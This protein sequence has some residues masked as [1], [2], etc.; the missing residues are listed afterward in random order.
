MI[1]LIYYPNIII[2]LSMDD[3]LIYYCIVSTIIYYIVDTNKNFENLYYL[4]LYEI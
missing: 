4:L 2:N 3:K 1:V